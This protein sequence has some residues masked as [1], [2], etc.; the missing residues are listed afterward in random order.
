MKAATLT[1]ALALIAPTVKAADQSAPP[2]E[3]KQVPAAETRQAPA[4]EANQTPSAVGSTVISADDSPLVRA[5]K[6][7]A[8]NRK[9]ARAKT[10]INNESVK[11]AENAHVTTA[12]QSPPPL[13][14][15]P[16]E[17][18]GGTPVVP[19]PP[20]DRAGTEKK[21]SDLQRE[22]A[23]LAQEAEQHAGEMDEDA[24]LQRL[25]EIQ[26]ESATLKKALDSHPSAPKKP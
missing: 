4:A 24:V 26:T 7:S 16:P 3:T 22:Q 5:A 21:L 18:T 6:T 19:E 13:R 14:L 20:F 8:A 10:V 17:A 23:L 11:H 25:S 15:P 12:N 9:R 1:L 2:P